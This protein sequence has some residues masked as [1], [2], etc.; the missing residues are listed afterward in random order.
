MYLSPQIMSDHEVTKSIVSDLPE[1]VL[2]AVCN[3]SLRG[4]VAHAMNHAVG[5]WLEYEGG[6]II[7]YANQNGFQELVQLHNR[8][9]PVTDCVNLFFIIPESLGEDFYEQFPNENKFIGVSNPRSKTIQ[10]ERSLLLIPNNLNNA[11]EQKELRF[12]EGS[13]PTPRGFMK[14][15]EL[16]ELYGYEITERTKRFL[17]HI[18]KPHLQKVATLPKPNCF[19]NRTLREIILS[20]HP[21]LSE[22]E[23]ARLE[24]ELEVIEG[25]NFENIFLIV[26]DYVDYAKV[27]GIEVGVGRGSVSNSLVSHLLGIT[28][29]HPMEY[30]LPFERFLNPDRIKMPDIDIDFESSKVASIHKYIQTTYGKD[31]VSLLRTYGTLS[32]KAVVRFAGKKLDIA[33]RDMNYASRLIGRHKTLKEATINSDALSNFFRNKMELANSCAVLE[34]VKRSVSVHP[35]GVLID[36]G[37]LRELL[38]ISNEEN[39]V[40]ICDLEEPEAE[41][42]GFLKFDILAL[43]TLDFMKDLKEE[44]GE[45][46]E[47]PL[48]DTSTFKLFAEG[49]TDGIFQFESDGMKETLK[50]IQPSSVLELGIVSA[51]YRPGPLKYI[52]QYALDPQWKIRY[53][54]FI[55]EVLNETNG[56]IVFQ[57]QVISILAWLND[58]SLGEADTLRRKISGGDKDVTNRIFREMYENPDRRFV[59][60]N[61]QHFFK[62]LYDMKNYSFPKGHAISYAL[63]SYKLAFYKKNFPAEFTKVILQ[64]RKELKKEIIDYAKSEGVEVYTPKHNQT[65]QDLVKENKLFLS[66]NHLQTKDIQSIYEFFEESK[67]QNWSEGKELFELCY[68]FPRDV[69]QT[70]IFSGTLS[71]DGPTK[72][73]IDTSDRFY[74]F[75]EGRDITRERI[76]MFGL[77]SLVGS[78]GIR[79]D[80]D[81]YNE[82][83]L[84]QEEEKALGCSTGIELIDFLAKDI[85]HI[86]ISEINQVG[87][88]VTLFG[89][90]TKLKLIKTKKGQN[91]AFITLKDSSGVIEGVV[92]PEFLKLFRNHLSVGYFVKLNGDIQ[93]RDGKLQIIAKEIQRS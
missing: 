86:K 47:I 46:I 54:K 51:M 21:N 16:I 10:N 20:E 50:K 11:N 19:G 63:F 6:N 48:D 79:R 45:A 1:N 24:Y 41:R 12:F 83:F 31:S 67:S 78:L 53:C 75:L 2:G 74:N 55:D 3:T 68:R 82:S 30:N 29:I 60:A 81:E 25:N 64:H 33:E 93:D 26:K 8:L 27:S 38:P 42:L 13:R 77:E 59:M 92:F 56:V 87:W 88:N 73:L 91:M 36:D 32:A 69:V 15:D 22:A 49:K 23:S 7:A 9:R 57:E 76:E 80:I 52:D 62:M 70:I 40:M 72:G 44:I 28:E 37:N 5:F 34:G 4:S 35:A 61:K 58:I 18:Q 43:K 14:E 65:K 85:E 84:I 89:A 17:T 90:I 71:F 66:L 39:D